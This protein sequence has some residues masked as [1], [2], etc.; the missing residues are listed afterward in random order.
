MP[1]FSWISAAHAYRLRDFARAEGLYEK[2]LESRRHHKAYVNALLD[3]SFCKFKLR[4]VREAEEYLREAVTIQPL[5]L[6]GWLRLGKLLLWVGKP[7]IAYNTLKDI[8]PSFPES[9]ELWG[10]TL[11]A[12]TIV[13]ANDVLSLLE[14]RPPR[15]TSPVPPVALALADITFGDRYSGRVFLTK[16]CATDNP[17]IEALHGMAELL[18]SEENYCMA[19][20]FLRRALYSSPDNP[21][22]LSL[23]SEVYLEDRAG[24]EYAVQLAQQSCQV[25]GWQ[26][27]RF[28]NQLVRAHLAV[29]DR[30]SALL[31]ASRALEISDEQFQ[32]R[33][34]LS[35]LVTELKT[36][37]LS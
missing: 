37:S 6:E 22:T 31:I 33:D 23:L 16:L 7:N 12:G 29:G 3:L 11:Y 34:Q 15:G 4:K 10:I 20:H 14:A 19:K 18:L 9:E 24:Y 5:L 28:M 36:Q 17:P 27:P 26:S 25:S 2:G 21:T 1:V 30:V 32:E 8:L 13:R 35:K